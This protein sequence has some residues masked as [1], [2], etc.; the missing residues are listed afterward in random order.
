MS[1]GVADSSV[2]TAPTGG[3]WWTRRG[4]GGWPT[5][6]TTPTA[7]SIGSTTSLP[8]VSAARDRFPLLQSTLPSITAACSTRGGLLIRAP[9]NAHFVS[10]LVFQVGSNASLTT[11]SYLAPGL[12]AGYGDP[13]IRT[14]DGLAYTFNGVGEFLLLRHLNTSTPDAQRTGLEVHSRMER[15]ALRNVSNG[16]VFTAFVF[17]LIEKG[18]LVFKLETRIDKS[19]GGKLPVLYEYDMQY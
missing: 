5:L 16:S 9:S 18:Q 3:S 13:H 10:P 1:S 17:A 12:A 2:C 11:R 6:R 8:T 7:G 4:P 15:A 19:T 14:L